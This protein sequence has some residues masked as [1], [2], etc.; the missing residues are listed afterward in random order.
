MN[1]FFYCVE[2]IVHNEAVFYFD[3]YYVTVMMIK[4]LQILTHNKHLLCFCVRQKS[5]FYI[6]DY[7]R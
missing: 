3:T 6:S 5:C 1:Y 4:N 2:E 7:G